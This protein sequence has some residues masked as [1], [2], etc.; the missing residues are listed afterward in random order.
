MN[1]N[2]PHLDAAENA[3]FQR[4]LEQISLEQLDIKYA[5]MKSLAIVPMFTEIDPGAETWTY[6]QFEQIGKAAP[7]VSFAEDFAKVNVKGLQYSQRMQSYGAGFD[8]SIQELRAALK[9]GRPLERQRADVA[10]KVI[11]VQLDLIL[12]VGDASQGL[13]GILNLAGT[14]TAAAATKA[15]SGLTATSWLS[16]A[17][18]LKSTTDEV[19]A[20][21]NLMCTKIEVDSQQ[22]ESPDTIVLPI[23]QY[24][25]IR[26]TRVSQYQE[27]SI[28]NSFLGRH[29][30]I[31]VMPWSRCL[32][33][34]AGNG[35]RAM[36]FSSNV[37]NVRGLLPVAF[38]MQA[39]QLVN[40]AYKVNCH[41]R[42]GGV[43][44]PYPKSIL[45]MD[46]I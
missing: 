20:D 2:L 11:D 18:A 45:Y 19:N 22:T 7:I 9:A 40:M 23:A 39:P 44:S 12:A 35:T 43:I 32:N 6:T 10:R 14:N 42:C 1:L 36:A 34:G 33:A 13:L 26:D 28:L 3:F 24:A 30:G 8:F 5:P 17:G 15:V 38:E 37:R 29:P 16:A 27:M 25:V 31:R 41:M 21:L 46:N 4:E